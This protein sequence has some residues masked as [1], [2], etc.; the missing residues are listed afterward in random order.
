VGV[1]AEVGRAAELA[2]SIEND[3][4]E[5]FGTGRGEAQAT[6]PVIALSLP[7]LTV[8]DGENVLKRGRSIRHS[9]SGWRLSR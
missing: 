9:F 8:L 6:A 2:A 7:G 1:A 4:K 5:T 3:P